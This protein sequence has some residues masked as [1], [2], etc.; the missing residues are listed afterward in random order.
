MRALLLRE[1]AAF[2]GRVPNGGVK[3]HA[4][5]PA[6][7]AHLAGRDRFRGVGRDAVAVTVGLDGRR[8]L[9]AEEGI[10]VLTRIAQRQ[11]EGD[12]EV[13]G[14]VGFVDGAAF[15]TRDSLD[16][17]QALD[18]LAGLRGLRDEKRRDVRG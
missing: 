4:G 2:A 1:R 5:D 10:D 16:A 6:E 13:L 15:Q 11:R 18:R 14:L 12:G 17:V 7:A 3:A 9:L 8:A